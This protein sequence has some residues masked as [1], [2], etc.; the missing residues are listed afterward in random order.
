MRPP[1]FVGMVKPRVTGWGTDCRHTHARQAFRRRQ[2]VVTSR[3]R[4]SL[5]QRSQGRGVGWQRVPNSTLSAMGR[6]DS[7]RGRLAYTA[8]PAHGWR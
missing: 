2:R 8:Q 3:C 7:G 1:D 6:V 5:P 4:R